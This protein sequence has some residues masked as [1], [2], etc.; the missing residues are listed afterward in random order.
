MIS[1]NST[2]ICWKST[3]CR[4]CNRCVRYKFITHDLCCPEAPNSLTWISYGVSWP[5]APKCVWWTVF[6]RYTSKKKLGTNE[7]IGHGVTMSQTWLSD[8]TTTTMKQ[9]SQ[10]VSRT[11]PSSWQWTCTNKNWDEI[12]D[13][14]PLASPCK[15]QT[16]NRQTE[17]V[18]VWCSAGCRW[19]LEM[20]QS[21]KD[22]WKRR[23]LKP[24]PKVRG[25]G[26][27]KNQ[28]KDILGRGEQEV[29]SL[30]GQRRWSRL[31]VRMSAR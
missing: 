24:I 16:V 2:D 14:I 15:R 20:G 22:S 11:R 31:K 1:F 8:W 13:E 21:S 18:N 10:C 23:I 6:N 3:M 5:N 9:L 12:P 26:H 4:S 27:A 17:H 25:T 7:T 19:D 28:R 30:Q 29:Q